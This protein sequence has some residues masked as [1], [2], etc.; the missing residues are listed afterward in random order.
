[1]A[2]AHIERL[3]AMYAEWARGNFRAGRELFA[4]DALFET[5]TDGRSTAVGAA[6]IESYMREFLAQ[7]RDF[8]TTAEEF[9]EVGDAILV[10]ERQHATGKSSGAETEMTAYSLW[11]FR[12]GLVVR[13]RWRTD[14]ASALEGAGAHE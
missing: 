4:P 5:I 12:D 2:Q 10:T 3:R 8:R 13:V 6:G 11:T 7:W 9:A 14:R 1:M